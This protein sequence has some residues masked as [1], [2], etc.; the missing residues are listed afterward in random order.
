MAPASAR[1]GKEEAGLSSA[2]AVGLRV[3]ARAGGWL[4]AAAASR[5]SAGPFPA[6]WHHPTDVPDSRRKMDEA[7]RIGCAR[8]PA[9]PSAPAAPAS[10]GCCLRSPP[11][12]FTSAAAAPS[13]GCAPLSL[14]LRVLAFLLLG[15]PALA[16]LL[17]FFFFLLLL[18]ATA[19][20]GSAWRP[21]PPGSPQCHRPRGSKGPA[22]VFL[23]AADS[24]Q[25]AALT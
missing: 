17:P 3:R 11:P 7:P 6:P 18:L 14:A 2:A 13:A 21:H 22:V 15:A 5:G 12:P 19:A 25:Q 9:P 23:S 24:T 4:S 16:R 1:E 8:P 10:R 20:R